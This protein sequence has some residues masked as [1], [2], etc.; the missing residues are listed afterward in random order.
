MHRGAP[1]LCTVL[2]LVLV[3][4]LV[5]LS[6]WPWV[7]KTP[8]LVMCSIAGY[9]IILLNY[10]LIPFCVSAPHHTTHTCRPGRYCTY[11]TGGESSGVYCLSL[12][13]MIQHFFLDVFKLV[14]LSPSCSCVGSS[15]PWHLS[16]I[17]IY[18]TRRCLYVCMIGGQSAGGQAGVYLRSGQTYV[19]IIA[20][21]PVVFETLLLLWDMYALREFSGSCNN[22]IISKPVRDY[23]MNGSPFN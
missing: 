11:L 20:L 10:I 4:V 6:L 18:S 5:V 22:S 8:P 16:L 13:N 12:H 2:G 9:Y 21:D 7:F 1:S 19:C 23:F 17:Y 15:N 14:D 3:L